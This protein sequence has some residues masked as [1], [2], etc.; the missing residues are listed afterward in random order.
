MNLKMR[1]QEQAKTNYKR[2]KNEKF[3]KENHFKKGD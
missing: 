1:L 2:S 3:G